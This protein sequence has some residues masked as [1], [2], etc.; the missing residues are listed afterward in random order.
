MQEYKNISG[1]RLLQS[2][3]SAADYV[4]QPAWFA[5]R[6]MN[7]IK[8]WSNQH[9]KATKTISSTFLEKCCIWQRKNAGKLELG[10]VCE[11]VV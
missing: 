2:S 4:R 9:R 5:H 8:R 7:L 11:P 10:S 1:L 6:R 3:G